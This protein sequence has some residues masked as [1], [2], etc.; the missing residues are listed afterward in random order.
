MNM[1]TSSPGN[2]TSEIPFLIRS[3]IHMRNILL[4]VI[5][6][7]L[8]AAA[9]LFMSLSQHVR[10]TLKMALVSMSL[11]DLLMMLNVTVWGFGFE[12]WHILYII[13]TS[14][15]V[16]YLTTS[17]LA[18][19]NYVAVFYPLR[20]RQI[21]SMG[22]SLAIL[23][24]C[25]LSGHL[26]GLTCLGVQMPADVACFVLTV[27]PRPGIVAV[28]SVCFACCC[29]VTFMSIR[30]LICI[31][32]K[33]RIQNN[34]STITK[35]MQSED[36]CPPCLPEGPAMTDAASSS[37]KNKVCLWSTR[38]SSVSPVSEYTL[39]SSKQYEPHSIITFVSPR[40]IEE[41]DSENSSTKKSVSSKNCQDEKSEG[42]FH[43]TSSCAYPTSQ[44]TSEFSPGPSSEGVSYPIL[45]SRELHG[46]HGLI[47]NRSSQAKNDIST[48]AY[49]FNI[50]RTKQRERFSNSKYLE[51][52]NQRS[53]KPKCEYYL[54]A[55]DTANITC[56]RHKRKI[57]RTTEI[58]RLLNTGQIVRMPNHWRKR[59][60]Q[61][62]VFG[63][64]NEKESLSK[65]DEEHNSN[66][67]SPLNQQFDTETGSGE[68]NLMP[69]KSDTIKHINTVVRL[70][71]NTGCHDKDIKSSYTFSHQQGSSSRVSSNSKKREYLF[72]N[73]AYH[74]GSCVEKDS[75]KEKTPHICQQA[76]AQITT[77]P[78][79]SANP[80]QCQNNTPYVW[81][82]HCISKDVEKFENKATTE[83]NLPNMIKRGGNS[84]YASSTSNQNESKCHPDPRTDSLG[85]SANIVRNNI[86]FKKEKEF[87]LYDKNVS[88]ISHTLAKT[89]DLGM[90]GAECSSKM[91][92]TPTSNSSNISQGLF[93]SLENDIVVVDDCNEVGTSLNP[94]SPQKTV[95]EK[96]EAFN[97]S[98]NDFTGF[99]SPEMHA[100]EGHMHLD[101]HTCVAVNAINSSLPDELTTAEQSQPAK[102]L[103]FEAASSTSR[104]E[105]RTEAMCK[106]AETQSHWRHR[107]QYT[108]L[109]LCSWCCFL[110]LPY[111]VY[112]SYVAIWEEERLAFSTSGIG[113]FCS[114][115][116][117]LNCITNPLLYAWRF[118]EWRAIWRRIVS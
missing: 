73:P 9:I 5:G 100:K 85:C 26:I 113:M 6:M 41:S 27:M 1:S 4:G 62:I 24:F 7:I 95:H 117:G 105:R 51:V 21:L 110:T 16:S 55:C 36:Q 65:T 43:R 38:N 112:G 76:T 54:D 63:I 53:L 92:S 116:V 10:P 84:I 71:F 72:V 59:H 47:S 49:A 50:T 14:V 102:S 88:K 12:C 86:D 13:T 83:S 109:I 57:Y 37:N 114:T 22:R 82:K 104:T 66:H 79:E 2:V 18:L 94:I 81:P 77:P 60:E 19:H 99:H 34:G 67:T 90:A 52:P 103:T 70:F 40:L 30:V 25:W 33:F 56:A 8:N 61:K 17:V 35:R 45:K 58:P 20:C 87:V 80:L 115:L 42:D 89:N 46:S 3:E 29:L 39:S 75:A 111:I 78:N 108:I 69:N 118:V 64:E 96:T 107:T 31:R 15:I 44:T 98:H 28:C 11:N 101:E 32:S 106:S 91:T 23:V 97:R 48:Q 74:E 68:S 93:R